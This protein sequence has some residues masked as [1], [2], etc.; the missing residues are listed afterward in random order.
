MAQFNGNTDAFPHLRPYISPTSPGIH[1]AQTTVWIVA[2]TL[3][4]VF[5]IERPVDANGTPIDIPAAFTT[6]FFRYDRFTRLCYLS[7]LS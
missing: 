7:D 1:L 6:G 5:N 3:L 2:A 4:Q